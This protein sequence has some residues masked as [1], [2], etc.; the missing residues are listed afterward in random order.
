MQEKIRQ[1]R[2]VSPQRRELNQNSL[3]RLGNGASPSMK[4]VR[5]VFV[6]NDQI[7]YAC[8]LNF[9][10]EFW[11]KKEEKIGSLTLKCDLLSFFSQQKSTKKNYL[12]FFFNI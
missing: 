4:K 9:M 12:N 7:S 1:G 3:S 8:T 5:P 11:C 2:G 10:S 6:L